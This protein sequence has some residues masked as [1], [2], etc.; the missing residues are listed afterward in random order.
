MDTFLPLIYSNLESIIFV[1]SAS[2][3]SLLFLLILF[4][5]PEKIGAYR[6]LMLTFSGYCLIF[7]L[8]TWL[9][10]PTSVASGQVYII[11][12]RRE[13]PLRYDLWKHTLVCMYST[14]IGILMYLIAVQFIYRYCLICKPKMI[15]YFS[16]KYLACWLSGILVV[17]VDYGVLT[18]FLARRT[19][20]MESVMRETLKTEFHTNIE[21][22]EFIGI[23]FYTETANKSIDWN[24]KTLLLIVNVMILMLIFGFITVYC[25]FKTYQFSKSRLE[26]NEENEKFNR[27]IFVA[28]VTQSCIPLI[29]MFLP[30]TIIIIIPLFGLSPKFLVQ[31][32]AI[33]ISIYP[34]L[35]PLAVLIIVSSYREF[36]I[37][38]IRCCRPKKMAAIL[39]NSC[40]TVDE[41]FETEIL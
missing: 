28:L 40:M 21:E 1:I 6:Y 26:Q 23:Q 17:A 15:I 39:K 25:A 24:L 12:V 41:G 14:S 30:I 38:C 2:I 29:F 11:F 19:T 33:S 22:V 32:S 36:F 4:K 35:D 5:S 9:G 20:E 13:N 27:Q 10:E 18:A 3:N 8:V 16:G 7:S 37:E 31:I 34:I